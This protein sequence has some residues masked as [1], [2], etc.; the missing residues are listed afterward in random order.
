M[1]RVRARAMF[2]VRA[3]AMRRVRARLGLRPR[4]REKLRAGRPL[5]AP[6]GHHRL[7]CAP[8]PAAPRGGMSKETKPH[9]PMKVCGWPS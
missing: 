2:R 7:K 3:R 5:A 4:V 8:R 1:F 9:L 6:S